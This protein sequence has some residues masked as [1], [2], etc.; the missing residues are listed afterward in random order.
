M[1]RIHRIAKTEIARLKLDRD[2]WEWLKNWPPT[3]EPMPSNEPGATEAESFLYWNYYMLG[4]PR[5]VPDECAGNDAS[6][7]YA[8]VWQ[9][10]REAVEDGRVEVVPLQDHTY[11]APFNKSFMRCHGLCRTLETPME[12]REWKYGKNYWEH[13]K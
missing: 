11:G 13:Y 10:I 3:V 4:E 5:L 6:W 9:S 8:C 1:G 7:Y 2:V 12:W